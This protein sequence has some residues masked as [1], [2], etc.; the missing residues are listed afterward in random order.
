MIRAVFMLTALAVTAKAIDEPK[1]R[2]NGGHL[3]LTSG[4][5]GVEKNVTDLLE[6]SVAERQFRAVLLHQSWFRSARAGA[7]SQTS[8]MP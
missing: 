3:Y 8:T 2:A 6:A 7:P 4:P 1:L 5:S